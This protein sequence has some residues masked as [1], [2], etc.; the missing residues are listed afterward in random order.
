MLV[1]GSFQC[2]PHRR[3][4]WTSFVE[5]GLV[6]SERRGGGGNLFGGEVFC[7]RARDFHEELEHPPVGKGERKIVRLG[8]DYSGIGNVELRR[9][10]VIRR[11]S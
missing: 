10:H 4:L 3:H 2:P 1:V 9:R 8:I 6:G 11:T 5:N 7:L